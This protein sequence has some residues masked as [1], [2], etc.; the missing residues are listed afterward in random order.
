RSPREVG[1][2]DERDRAAGRARRDLAERGVGLRLSWAEA[3]EMVQRRLPARHSFLRDREQRWESHVRVVAV[4]KPDGT[5]TP[6]ERP[7]F[8]VLKREAL[9]DV[10]ISTRDIADDGE[11]RTLMEERAVMLF[12]EG[13]E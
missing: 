1:E 12:P 3:V 2:H 7:M 4:L 13:T 10:V 9:V 6:V 11:R 5:V 8:P